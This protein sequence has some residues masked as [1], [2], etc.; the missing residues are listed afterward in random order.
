MQTGTVF[1]I[2][3]FSI[4]DGPGIRTTVFMKG[5]PLKCLWCHNP[6]SKSS[7]P[8]IF[9]DTNKCTGCGRCVPACNLCLHSIADGVHLFNRED[10]IA[11]GECADKCLNDALELSGYVRSVDEVIM[12]VLKDKVFYENSGGGMTVSGGEPMYQFEFT[13]ELLKAAKKEGLHICMET[14]GFAKEENYKKIA[15]LVDIFLFDYKLTSPELHKKYTGVSNE[16]ILNNLRMLDSMGCKI[17]LRCPI[18]PT[19]NDT[20][21]HF[22]G[23]AE[24]ANSLSNILEINIEPYH[25]LGNGKNE[26]L[27]IDYELKELTFPSDDTVAEWMRIISEKTSVTV[28][29]A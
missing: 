8:Q 26:M 10:C 16:L 13:Y 21:E 15:E 29:K 18:I 12:E 11:C 6:E 28:K 27:G 7:K 23:I 9:F 25:P 3:K 20:D 1:N 4:N 2:Q 17:I 5:C 22:C 19:I 14:C 24:T